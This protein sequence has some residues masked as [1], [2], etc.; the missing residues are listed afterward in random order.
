M[1]ITVIG[2]DFGTRSIGVAVGQDLTCSAQPLSA[3]R[4]DGG[5]PDWTAIEKIIREWQPDQLVVGLPLNMDGT[6]QKVTELARDFASQLAG[7]FHLPC[8]L[9][10]ER[11]TTVAA[12]E[13]LFEKGGY[14]ALK[15]GMVDSVSAVL[16]TESYFENR[17]DPDKN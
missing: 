11:L 17:P 7:R 13:Y 3:V 6:D 5:K 14:R 2:F 16:I 4:A 9:Q 12:K 15:K 10:D 1:S 8:A